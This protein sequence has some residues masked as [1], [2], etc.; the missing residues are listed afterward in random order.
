M[1]DRLKKAFDSIHAE[2]SLKKSTQEYLIKEL[3]KRTTHR[4]TSHGSLRYILPAAACFVFVLLGVGGYRMYFT[5]V[6]VISIDVNPSL[7]WSINRFDKIISVE[8]YNTDGEQLAASLDVTYKNYE[9]ALQLLIDDPIITEC[10]SRDE[11]LSITVVGDDDTQNSQILQTVRSCTSGIQ[12]SHCTSAGYS[13]LEEAHEVGLSCGKYKAYC[14]LQT[15]DPDITPEDIM[16]MTM[17][18]IRDRISEL[19]GDD[20]IDTEGLNQNGNGGHHQEQGHGN[21]QHKGQK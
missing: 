6:S 15:L 11:Y 3:E 17:K 12:N 8:T 10:L 18:E 19:T 1:S 20:T 5:P 14:I 16:N 7:E 21:H 4:S 13:E 9:E 2:E